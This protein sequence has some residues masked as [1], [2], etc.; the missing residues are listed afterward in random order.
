MP[1]SSLSKGTRSR[2]YCDEFSTSRLGYSLQAGDED[3]GER[4]T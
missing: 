2:D 4:E 3:L 1:E